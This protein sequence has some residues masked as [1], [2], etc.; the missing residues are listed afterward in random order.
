MSVKKC[1]LY[2]NYTI[3]WDVTHM[4]L[5][6]T[7]VSEK[8]S[9]SIIRVKWI[10]KLG[11]TLLLLTT[12]AVTSSLS[13]FTLMMESIRSSEM[14]VLTRATRGHIPEDSILPGHRHKN[15]K[16]HL[17]SRRPLRGLCICCQG[18]VLRNV[19][20]TYYCFLS[21]RMVVD[22]SE[23]NT[24]LLNHNWRRGLSCYVIFM[25]TQH[26]GASNMTMWGTKTCVAVDLPT[27]SWITPL[28]PCICTKR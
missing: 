28:T 7:D 12:N 1:S 6:R 4:A 10:N 26:S 2:T 25:N 23:I 14:L 27:G 13:L 3:F 21:V 9:A 19:D 16:I 22:M 5:A 17:L 20:L 11:T 8:R 24:S 18:P 15:I